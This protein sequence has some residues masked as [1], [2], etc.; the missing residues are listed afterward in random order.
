MKLGNNVPCSESVDIL[1]DLVSPVKSIYT[2][3]KIPIKINCSNKG[4]HSSLVDNIFL[5]SNKSDDLNV[6]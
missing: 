1:Y 2:T 4:Y 5:L 6:K 3:S